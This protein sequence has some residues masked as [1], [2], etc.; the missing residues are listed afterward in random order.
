MKTLTI[1]GIDSD[2]SQKLKHKAYQNGT[3]IN[4]LALSILHKALGLGTEIEFPEYTD[5]D[6]LSGTWSSED[7]T[8]FVK[9]I[10][11]SSRIDPEQWQ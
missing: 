5:L 1:R 9:A 2:L 11:E 10:Q 8:S 6:H 3:S 7:E 4:Q